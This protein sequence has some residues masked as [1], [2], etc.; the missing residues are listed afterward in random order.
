MAFVET[1]IQVGGALL[2]YAT[3]GLIFYGIWQGMQRT[4]GRTSGYMG[5]AL[6]SP[7]FY[8]VTSAIFFGICILG[9]RPLPLSVDAPT[10]T[11]M[12]GIGACFLF[13]GL[14]L[15]M[16]GRLALGRNYFVSTGLGAQVFT[17]QTLI[18]QGP[19]AYVRHPMYLGLIL[20]ACGSALVYATWTTLLFACFAPG[21]IVR[22]RREEAVLAVEFG[23]AW[24]DY[25]KRVPAFI[26]I[27][28]N[29]PEILL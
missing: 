21:I 13:P 14:G 27:F 12:L 29:S 22:A 25:C 16:W 28:H 11:W 23:E 18:T 5:S 15:V 10:R 8:L 19:Y 1:I 9:W 20:A 24:Q 17:D 3:L 26:P 7:W 4:T 2:A 6:R